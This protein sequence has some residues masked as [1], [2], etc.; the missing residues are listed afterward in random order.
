ME[1]DVLRA[2]L[3]SVSTYASFT[4][5]FQKMLKRDDEDFDK[6][7]RS[8][9]RVNGTGISSEK[10]GD[11]EF[12]V[13]VGN[14][15]VYVSSGYHF[16]DDHQIDD[17]LVAFG[18]MAKM[19]D[20]LLAHDYTHLK[21]GIQQDNSNTIFKSEYCN[22]KPWDFTDPEAARNEIELLMQI[23][24]AKLKAVQPEGTEK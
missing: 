19:R 3:N 21:Q 10:Y 9:F 4:P 24:G 8:T 7:S 17:A 23:I 11:H 22:N 20:E 14:D 13:D 15:R 12:S 18:D 5:E 1:K 2:T 6:F 16:E